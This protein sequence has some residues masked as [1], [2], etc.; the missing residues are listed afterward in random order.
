METPA[1]ESGESRAKADAALYVGSLILP[2]T[3]MDRFLIL[4]LKN[5]SSLLSVC[6]IISLCV[7]KRVIEFVS[8]ECGDLLKLKEK[9]GHVTSSE[10]ETH[11]HT[12]DI[13]SLTC[14]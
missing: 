2:E 1:V 12:A 5:L 9:L 6:D 10:S 7:Q 8:S 13:M 3:F 11:Q 4:T 14:L